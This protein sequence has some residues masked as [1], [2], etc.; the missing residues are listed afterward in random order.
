MI[1]NGLD[2]H[3]LDRGSGPAV[4]LLHGFTGS[5]E[6]WQR[7]S[8]RLVSAGWRVIAPDLPGHGETRGS[9]EPGRYRIE[10]AAA[11][12]IALVSRLGV[13]SCAL[14]GY[15]MGGRLALYTALTYPGHIQALIL[16]SASPGLASAAERE[17]R[18]AADE[19]LA[20]RIEREGLDAFVRYWEELPLFS[21]LHRLPSEVRARLRAE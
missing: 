8:A 4:V 2:Y 15:S 1:I 12:V 13:D 3:Y 21:G 10:R 18:R 11:D 9:Y 16:E 5:S 19:A 6:M 7:L 14:L 20:N 17:A